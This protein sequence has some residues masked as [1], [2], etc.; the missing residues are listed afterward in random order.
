MKAESQPEG[1]NTALD[2]LCRR[3]GVIAEYEDI[4]GGTQRATDPTRLAL[5]DALGALDDESDL[6][7]ALHAHQA[8][9]WREVAPRVA[10]FC[11]DEAPYRMRFHFREQD[12]QT[13]YRWTFALEGAEVRSGEFRPGDLETLE[14]REVDGERYVE[15]AFD[16]R[17]RLPC[18]YHRY[19]LRGPGVSDDDWVSFIVAPESCYLPPAIRTGARV[20]GP[21]LQLYGVRS[22]RNW[23]MGDYTDLRTVVEQ[24]G[25]RGAG[26]VGAN[27]LHALYPHNP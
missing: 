18:G 16:W 17:D 15:V 4:W 22:E 6:D 26:V 19:A 11:V 21:V 20:W 5:L 14:R 2:A 27:P 25:H 9:A 1:H 3:F 10:V 23:G 7:T 8:R 12:A 13:T 24:W